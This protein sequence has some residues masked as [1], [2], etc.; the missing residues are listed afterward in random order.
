M[1]PSLLLKILLQQPSTCT[2]VEDVTTEKVLQ[3][4]V[5]NVE[6]SAVSPVNLDIMDDHVNTC[7]LSPLYGVT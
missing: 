3:P 1:T 5:Y 7:S 2:K 6:K 4:D